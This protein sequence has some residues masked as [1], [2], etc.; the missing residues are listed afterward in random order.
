[1][2][3]FVVLCKH[4]WLWQSEWRTWYIYMLIFV[5]WF[6]TPQSCLHLN[7]FLIKDTLFIRDIVIM[8]WGSLI[9]LSFLYKWFIKCK[10]LSIHTCPISVCSFFHWSCHI[11]SLIL[12]MS[13]W[14]L[15][16]QI[17]HPW[18]VCCTHHTVP[19]FTSFYS[20]FSA[21]GVAWC[22]IL[23]LIVCFLIL[24]RNSI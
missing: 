5:F 2:D 7:P 9:C 19:N 11:V 1:M 20:T 10:A 13:Y 23:S 12:F 3:K 17:Y 8:V 21:F 24:E 16:C 6:S 18:L 4:W 14:F 15:C 22:W